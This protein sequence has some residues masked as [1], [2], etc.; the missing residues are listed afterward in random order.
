[1]ATPL[2]RMRTAWTGEGRLALHRVVEEMAEECVTL[3]S[4]EQGLGVLLEEAGAAG[5]DDDKEEEIHGV[6]D[7]LS[8]WCNPSQ[9]IVPRAAPLAGSNE[10]GVTPQ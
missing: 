9:R 10:G 5:A 4:L 6:F 3:E 2:E 7:R 8:G 1:M